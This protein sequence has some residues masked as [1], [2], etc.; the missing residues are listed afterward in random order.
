MACIDGF[1]I[2]VPTAN[3]QIFIAHA[4][5]FDTAFVERGETRVVGC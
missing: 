4:T 2:G 3:K 5:V 1:V